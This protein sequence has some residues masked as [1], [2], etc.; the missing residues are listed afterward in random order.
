M[1]WATKF[2]ICIIHCSPYIRKNLVCEAQVSRQSNNRGFRPGGLKSN[3]NII[4]INA[5]SHHLSVSR[6]R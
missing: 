6:D 5:C 2:A 4:A 1:Q 3:V